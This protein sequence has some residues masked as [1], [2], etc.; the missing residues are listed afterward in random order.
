MAGKLLV[1]RRQ[2]EWFDG[3]GNFTRQAF[4][5]F[6]DLTNI[7]NTTTE[8]I[9]EDVGE[10][11]IINRALAVSSA[12]VFKLQSQINES[13]DRIEDNEID[14]ASRP[15]M[16]DIVKTNQRIDELIDELIAEIRAIAPNVEL[17]NKAVCLQIATLEQLKLLNL[18]T[19]E[20]LETE[21]DESDL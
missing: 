4:R 9:I 21:L 2:N 20:A 1:P 3:G 13:N 8:I 7:T 11:A 19:E 5:F 18:R 15:R 12:Q 6:E 10:G 14:L 17:E 16:S